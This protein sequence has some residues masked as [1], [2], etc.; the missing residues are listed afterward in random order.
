MIPE[1][2][3]NT[4]PRIKRDGDNIQRHRYKR[5]HNTEVQR[6]REGKCKWKFPKQYRMKLLL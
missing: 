1:G 2:L 6:R 5:K 4:K 3:K